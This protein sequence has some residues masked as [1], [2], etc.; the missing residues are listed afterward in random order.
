MI[1]C[2]GSL[3]MCRCDTLR[4][5]SEVVPEGS[6]FP[7]LA[8]R[9]RGRPEPRAFREAFSSRSRGPHA[10]RAGFLLPEAK[11]PRKGARWSVHRATEV[12][13]PASAKRMQCLHPGTYGPMPASRCLACQ[14]RGHV[15]IVRGVAPFAQSRICAR[16]P[17]P[18]SAI[19]PGT[20]VHL[21]S[22]TPFRRRHPI[23][24]QDVAC[25]GLSRR[26]LRSGTPRV[27]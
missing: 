20:G 13:R 7:F 12:S 5:G 23:C 1:S 11:V 18:L 10:A 24:H 22:P 8:D 25:H 17:T 26:P 19:V 21:R 16:S 3:A 27:R 15:D 6:A 9:P 14:S 4:T 2:A